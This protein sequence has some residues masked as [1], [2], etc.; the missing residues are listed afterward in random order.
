M[1]P[2]IG[3]LL[4]K[5]AAARFSR[6]LGSL[7]EHGVPVVTALD[8][9]KSIIGNRVLS[10]IITQAEIEVQQG[11]ELGRALEQHRA[12]PLLAT[13]MIKVGEKAVPWKKC[14]NAPPPFMK[15]RWIPPL[16][17]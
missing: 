11:G 8:I 15:K 12:F 16:R 17:P 5:S 4:K 13:Q 9:A 1:L 6:I 2:K 14:W 3:S 7:L 10:G